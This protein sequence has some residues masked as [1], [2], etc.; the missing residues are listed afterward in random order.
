VRQVRV[1]QSVF[2][3]VCVCVCEGIVHCE[4]VPSN[5][6]VNSDFYC[7][8]LRY[9]RENMQRQRPELWRNHNWLLHHDNAPTHTFLKTIEFVTNNN[10]VTV[11]LPP[12]SPDLGPCDFALFPKLKMKLK[13]WRFE[14][15][16]EWKER[17][18]VT[19]KWLLG[20]HELLCQPWLQTYGISYCSYKRNLV[21]VAIHT[22]HYLNWILSLTSHGSCIIQP[23]DIYNFGP[24][25][26]FCVQGRERNIT[27]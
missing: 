19:P 17:I 15:V 27:G 2:F 24:V 25:G 12:Y 10:M 18:C 6:M 5:T 9:L 11:S 1:Q 8:I 7:D 13:G 26:Q 3:L 20:S 22:N 23:D 16:S 14:T 21:Y 4:L